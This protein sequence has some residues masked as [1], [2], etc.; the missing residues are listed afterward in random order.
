MIPVLV[1]L[2]LLPES[3]S[4]SPLWYLVTPIA[5]AVFI[6]SAAMTPNSRL[7]TCLEWPPIAYLGRISYGFYLYHNFFWLSTSVPG[8]VGVLLDMAANLSVGVA[9]AAA[10][11]HLVERPLMR[12]LAQ[13]WPSGTRSAAVS[14]P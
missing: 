14:A 12:L 10:S 8:H 2:A 3:A 6:L 7:V 13:P 4:L 5:A 1:V 9:V 11:Y